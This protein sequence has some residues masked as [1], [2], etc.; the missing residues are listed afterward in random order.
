M[1][2]AFLFLTACSVL[3]SAWWILILLER[4]AEVPDREPRLALVLPATVCLV[5]VWITFFA[6]QP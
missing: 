2:L 5:V 3:L 1:F 6:M 4:I